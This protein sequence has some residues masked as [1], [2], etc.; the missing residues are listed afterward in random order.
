MTRK[1]NFKALSLITAL[2]VA[3]GALA[4]ATPA[5]AAEM[6]DISTSETSVVETIEMT[7][8]A[9]M[10]RSKFD[11]LL[12]EE[13]STR[14]SYKTDY[15][16]HVEVSGEHTGAWHSIYGHQARMCIAFKPVD[17]NAAL[18]A[19]LNSGFWAWTLHYNPNAVD[20]DGYY[21]YVGPW[22][23]ITYQGAYR[24]HYELF[25]TGGSFST[26]ESERTGSFHVWVDYK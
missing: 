1:I 19:Y 6:D 12:N 16:G 18:S 13:A 5:L 15:W 21:M 8:E 17:G 14:A 23:D 2:A 11:E 24:L 20:D 7:E 25:T 3:V 4:G 9:E 26:E 22:K 10:L